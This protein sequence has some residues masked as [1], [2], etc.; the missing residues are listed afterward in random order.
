MWFPRSVFDKFN[1]VLRLGSLKEADQILVGVLQDEKN[2]AARPGAC[3][4]CKKNLVHQ[5]LP[6]LEVFV[7]ACPEKHGFWMTKENSL[8]LK[9]FISEQIYQETHRKGRTSRLIRNFAIGFGAVLIL[10]LSLPALKNMQTRQQAW[11]NQREDE[12]ISA[13][14]WPYRQISLP[15]IPAISSIGSSE[16]LVYLEDWSTLM[17]ELISNRLNMESVLQTERKPEEYQAVLSFYLR[18]QSV[19]AEKLGMLAVP[20]RLAEFHMNILRGIEAQMRFYTSYAMEKSK[21]EVDFGRLSRHPDLLT[22]GQELHSAYREILRVYPDLD[23]KTN[24]A[25]EERLNWAATA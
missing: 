13:A 3:P 5:A 14:Y 17:G 7:N 8:G 6:Y 21:G 10:H 1:S 12:K 25:I 15:S 2:Q 23:S 16:E 19:T 4:H 9:K 24:A 20:E 18:R 11:M 22:S